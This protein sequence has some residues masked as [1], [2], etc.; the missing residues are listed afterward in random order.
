MPMN[1]VN[2]T[3]ARRSSLQSGCTG[4]RDGRNAVFI[5]GGVLAALGHGPVL[6]RC[7]GRASRRAATHM[8]T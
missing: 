8:R 7:A 5:A 2:R 4:L 3:M 6:R 1:N